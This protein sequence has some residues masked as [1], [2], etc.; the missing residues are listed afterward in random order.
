MPK[1]PVP[2]TSQKKVAALE[3]GAVS[4]T[5]LARLS[6][7]EASNAYLYDTSRPGKRLP[8]KHG[9]L[10]KRL[11]VSDKIDKCETCGEGV[12]EC[13]GHFGAIR[14]AL[15]VFHIGYF[16]MVVQVLQNICK[17]CSHILLPARDLR[18]YLKRVRNPN[19]D[20]VQR[21]GVIKA[22]NA[23]CR[24]C[25]TCP[26]CG[27]A[28]GTVKKVGALKVIH[29][30]Y[31]SARKAAQP[32]IEAFR[33]TFA[34]A[35]QAAP[36]LR[37]HIPKAQDDL[38]PKRALDLFRAIPDEH[39]ECMGMDPIAGR[40]ELF[41]WTAVPVPPVA[42]RPSVGQEASSNEDDVTVLL[43]DVVIVNTRV[44]EIMRDGKDAKI[45]MEHWD[46]L[47]LQCAMLVNSDLPGVT[48]MPPM[49]TRIKRGFVQ[50]L[51]GKQGR[52][53]GNLSGKRVDFS[54]RTVISPD[55]NLRI[56]Q[57]AVPDRV[58][59]I[60]TYPEP[61]TAH[62]KEVLRAAVRN[63]PDV[64]PGAVYVKIA[65]T[66]EKKFLKFGREFVAKALAEG[67]V[68]ERHM[69]DGDVVLFNRQPSLHKLSIM[70]HF[71]KIR[72]WRTFRLNECVCT[73]YNA[74]FDGDEMNLHL[75]QTEE[76]RAEAMTLMGVKHNLVTPRNGEPLI[77]ATQDFISSAYLLTRRDVF[78][79]RAWISQWLCGMGD[80]F[81]HIELPPPTIIKPRALWTGRQ[82][83][84]VLIRPNKASPVVINLETKTRNYDRGTKVP[85]MDCNDGYLIVRNSEIM[86]GVI[87]K[88]VV[89]GESKNG[90]FYTI[91]RDYGVD[92][93]AA[94]MNRLAKMCARFLG[95]RG[96]SI[97]IDD[98]QPGLVLSRRKDEVVAK[99]YSDT[100]ELIRKSE[101]GE[102]ENLPG[103]NETQT[104]E[105]KISG[106]LSKIR[107]D[108]GGICLSELHRHN[109]PII[110]SLCGS[111][112]SK[113][114]VSQ[115]VACV[116]QQIISGQRI[117]N[118]FVDRSLPHFPKN[119]R[120]PAA[121][122]FVRN[123]FYS[124]LTPSEFLFHAVSGREGLVDTAVKT[125]E[126]GYMQRRLMKAL[127]DLVSHYDNSVRNSVGGIIQFT[128]GDDLLDPANMEGDKQPVN[129]NRLLLHCQAVV[130]TKGKGAM[131]PWE[132]RKTF[133]DAFESDKF[134]QECGAHFLEEVRTFVD[135]KIVTK[136]AGIRKRFGANDGLMEGEVEAI[137]DPV[138]RAAVDNSLK[139]TPEQC[140]LFLDTCLRKYSRAKMEPG[141]AVGAVGAQSIGEPGTQM[142]LKTFHFAGVASMNVTLGVPRI[143][144]IINASKAINTPI[145]SAELLNN[146]DEKVARIVKGR[147]EK[148]TLE[149]VA[150]FIEV[151]IKEHDTYLTI[152]LDTDAIEKLQ[153][154]VDTHG[155]ANAIT[156]APKLKLSHVHVHAT[157]V[158][159]IDVEL[160]NPSEMSSSKTSLTPAGI[161]N[162][163]HT[164]KRALPKVIIKGIPTVNRAVINEEKDKTFKL[165]VEGYGLRHVMNT[166]GVRGA[167]V[168]SNHIMEVLSVLGIEAARKTIVK[169]VIDVMSSHG[170][171]IDPRH[172]MLLADLMTFKGEVLGITRFGIA[173]MKDSVLMLASFEKTT[174]HLF[175]ASFYGKKDRINGV[176][177]CIIMGV[178]MLIGTGLF[179]LKQK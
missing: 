118:G 64:H 47:Q 128:Y 32:A 84:S 51:K 159:R 61:V 105:N 103:C 109:A 40:P 94:C 104:L 95:N 173:K 99:G 79:D 20:A 154:E 50:R 46:F 156:K 178:P 33:A 16:K 52:F 35:A 54:G 98:V 82:L 113:I 125:A 89:G 149:D 12:Q 28:N 129:L 100:D 30:K 71:A 106:V 153:L 143:K 108:V 163:L 177:E 11:G 34:T 122:G 78:F 36:D 139:F 165:L 142:T 76:A 164:L 168:T 97:G 86:C 160:P 111:K 39:V 77:A 21:A 8:Q 38:N 68:V 57:V 119:S 166:E 167:N 66:G 75:P 1:L 7:L 2:D 31:K 37:S 58:A 43:S 133:V 9:V 140:T 135:D 19:L 24:K 101:R 127:E 73:P 26:W 41:I 83:F 134:T 176:S 6:V 88:S 55:P 123:S 45:L 13:V 124:G 87:D 92:Q 121:R 150:E 170:M 49:L 148:T 131:M 18:T 93:A 117:P 151:V 136:L 126:T 15:P 145:I 175:E 169:E 102:L 4:H 17:S 91:M 72:P 69:R 70:S 74:D 144:E 115:M 146:K 23:A 157:A 42:I 22:I 5:S 27:E 114:N 44:R 81:M 112:G 138:V 14:L 65:A 53:R 141:T 172:V 62:N 132:I 48:N 116:G 110:M 96:F 162:R 67:D 80:G 56:D 171:T 63:G 147:V 59:K 161:L 3:F 29:E 174:D 107:D 179:K 60:L 25:G 120:T 152:K 155:I 90:I 85:E 158:N 137:A 130:D 10:D